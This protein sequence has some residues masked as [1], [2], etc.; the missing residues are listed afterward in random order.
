MEQSREGHWLF[1]IETDDRPGAAAAL[2]MVFSGRGIQIESFIGY[3]DPVYSAGRDTGII[4]ITFKAFRHRMEMV[5]RVLQ[6]LEVVHTV[7]CR[8]YADE[9]LVKTATVSLSRWDETVENMLHDFDLDLTSP[10]EDAPHPIAILSGRPVEVDRAV[11]TLS[12]RAWLASATYA[13]LPP[14]ST[15]AGD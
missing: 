3:G 9:S 11:S 4:V 5:Q 12:E 1:L 8:D 6:R 14:H 10:R 2:A 7:D 13:F 15:A